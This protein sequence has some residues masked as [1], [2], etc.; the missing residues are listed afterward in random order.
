M[1]FITKARE[2]QIY[3]IKKCVNFPKRYTFY[4]SQP[5]VNAATNIHVLV[6]KANT[7][8]PTNKH[9]SQNRIDLLV[10][11]KGELYSL[12][13][14]VEVAKELFD[15]SGKSIKHW[16]DIIEDEIRLVNGTLK[17]DRAQRN[18]FEE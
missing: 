15:I 5:I 6:K 18:K 12:I 9:E 16:M 7:I 3:T 13:S 8:Y 14:L 11:A 1:E 4:V 10:E 17:K 2:L